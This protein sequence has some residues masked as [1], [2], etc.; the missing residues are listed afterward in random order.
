MN[1]SDMKDMDDNAIRPDW[2]K[3]I[4]NI[5]NFVDKL[6]Y[7][8]TRQ[9]MM[10]EHQSTRIKRLERVIQDSDEAKEYLKSLGKTA[11]KTLILVLAFVGVVSLIV[12]R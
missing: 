11:I 10:I 5:E 9:E 7:Q 6:S 1:N 3:Q 2:D 12:G 8:V 4:N